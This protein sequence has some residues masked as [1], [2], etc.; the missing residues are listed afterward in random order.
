MSAKLSV[1][2]IS[3]NE[4]ANIR[5]CIQ[6]VLQVADEVLVLDSFSSD[7]TPNICRSLK[8]RFEQHP[9]DGHVEQKNRAVERCEND[10]VLSLDADER[11][12]QEL[13]DS[14]LEEK[15]N[16]FKSA[17]AFEFNRRNFY[18]KKWI[19]HGG[20]Y[21][22]RKIRLWDRRKGRWNGINP[23]DKVRLRSGAKLRHMSGDLLHFT[24]NGPEEHL[25]QA[26]KF[27]NIGGQHLRDKG[28]TWLFLKWMLSP[29]WRLFKMLI[30]KGGCRDGRQG[31]QIARITSY[32]VWLKYGVA[33]GVLKG[34]EK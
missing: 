14:I 4:E 32:E 29:P 34:E 26:K 2:I 17:D 24:F 10:W 1:A 15:A 7:T 21:P 20:W 33:L 28:K 16:G 9:F 12:T 27:G 8:V 13:A 19:K 30:L 18:G 31:F 25:K 22:D 3:F 11:L 5:E 23:H 6:S